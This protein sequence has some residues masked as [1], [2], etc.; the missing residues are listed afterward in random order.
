MFYIPRLLSGITLTLLLSAQSTRLQVA[1]VAAPL[2]Q[3]RLAL[4]PGAAAERRAQLEAMFRAVGCQGEL[5]TTLAVPHA[6]QPDVICRLPGDNPS[7]G[8]IVVGAHHDHVAIG[9]GAVDDWSGAALLPSLYQALKVE[10]RNHDFV[11]VGFAAEEVGLYGSREYVR[12]IFK[13]EHV[14]IQAMINLECLGLSPPAVWAS[15]ADPRLLKAYGEVAKSL[16]MAVQWT[17][18]DNLGDDDSHP[19]L[20]AKIPVMTIHSLTAETAPILHSTRDQVGAIRPDDYYAAY[21]VAA[22]YLA[23]LDMKM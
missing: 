7:A 8:V 12:R 13:G 11:F 21:R 10:P 16:G 15:R 2:I 22:T 6:K 1:L 4:V 18:V 17:N 19:F 9:R 14:N 20:N 5:L 23:Y 3:E